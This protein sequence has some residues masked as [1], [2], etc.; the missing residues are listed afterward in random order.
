MDQNGKIIWSRHNEIQ[1]TNVK[2]KQGQ[3][4]EDGERLSLPVKELGN[5]EIYPQYLKH[6]SNGRF[7]VACGDGEYIIYTALAWRNKVY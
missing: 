3:E 4:L 6:N 1:T 5:C 7:V 2:V